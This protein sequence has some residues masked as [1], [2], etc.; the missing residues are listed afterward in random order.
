MAASC[1]RPQALCWSTRL[2][3]ELAH[4]FATLP[5]P[6]PFTHDLGCEAHSQ[7][8]FRAGL[9]RLFSD[10]PRLAHADVRDFVLANM[11]EFESLAVS[12]RENYGFDFRPRLGLGGAN[13]L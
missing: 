4:G 3:N 10:V 6:Q 11:E 8:E 9:A 2:R 12:F 1:Y 5:L 13:R 7:P